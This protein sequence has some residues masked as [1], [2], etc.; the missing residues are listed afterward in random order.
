M[1]MTSYFRKDNLSVE[2]D[3]IEI[4]C[5]T[6]LNFLCLP[7]RITRDSFDNFIAIVATDIDLPLSGRIGV[8]NK[9]LSVCARA[10]KTPDSRLVESWR[11]RHS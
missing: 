3:M 11:F 10:V 4:D 2:L 5:H 6:P 1:L 7:F 8:H 9:V